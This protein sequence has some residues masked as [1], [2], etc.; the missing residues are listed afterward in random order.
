MTNVF[1]LF[2]YNNNYYYPSL[3]ETL[4]M[5]RIFYDNLL[6]ISAFYPFVKTWAITIILKHIPL[7]LSCF[8]FDVIC[9]TNFPWMLFLWISNWT[10]NP[11]T[12]F[13]QPYIKTCKNVFQS[14]E[15]VNKWWWKQQMQC[16]MLWLLKSSDQ[17]NCFIKNCI[18]EMFYKI[19]QKYNLKKRWKYSSLCQFAFQRSFKFSL[20]FHP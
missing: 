20:V 1:N 9:C 15:N 13:F 19:H 11:S 6:S 12:I 18:Y 17:T 3:F 8:S 10:L 14:Y 4:T 7:I 5:E 2:C 16:S